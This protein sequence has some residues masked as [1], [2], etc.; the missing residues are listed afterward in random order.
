MSEKSYAIKEA[1]V[2]DDSMLK[3]E[4]G[5]FYA[6]VYMVMFL[7]KDTLPDKMIYTVG[8][9]LEM[10]GEWTTKTPWVYLPQSSL[11]YHYT[12]MSDE[13]TE[14]EFTFAYPSFWQ[15]IHVSPSIQ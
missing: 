9:P 4:N 7:K 3:V 12:D 6:P 11:F 5:V 8:A 10:A 14:L 2:F 13:N 15:L 1:V